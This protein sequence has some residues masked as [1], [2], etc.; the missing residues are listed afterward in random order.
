MEDGGL[1]KISDLCYCAWL[2]GLETL[3]TSKFSETVNVIKLIIQGI[4]QTLAAKHPIPQ[5]KL[6]EITDLVKETLSNAKP[7]PLISIISL[8][9]AAAAICSKQGRFHDS[10][11]QDHA[12]DDFL[13]NF[14]TV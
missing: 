1:K 10:H 13:S 3:A 14:I 12:Q 8:T 2:L 5:A 9:A 7:S 4:H 6:K 11:A